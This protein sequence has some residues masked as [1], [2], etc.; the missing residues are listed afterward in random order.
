MESY[1]VYNWMKAHI[2][3]YDEYGEVNMTALAEAAANAIYDRA[4]TEEEFEIA[5]EVTE[6]FDRQNT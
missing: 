1:K 5:F 3:D 4:A 6:A 2:R